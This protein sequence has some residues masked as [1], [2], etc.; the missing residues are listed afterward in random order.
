MTFKWIDSSAIIS[1]YRTFE[2]I[3]FWSKS[4]VR[5][6]LNTT[7]ANT[8]LGSKDTIILLFVSVLLS[9]QC[10]DIHPPHSCLRKPCEDEE[11]PQKALMGWSPRYEVRTSSSH[12][13]DAPC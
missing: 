9:Y 13:L 7:A 2:A 10:Q 5:G 6:I 3:R 4:I 12:T 8:A 1:R 11:S